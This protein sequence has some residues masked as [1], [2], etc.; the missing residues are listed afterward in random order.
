MCFTDFF[1]SFKWNSCK[2]TDSIL[3]ATSKFTARGET[4]G[5]KEYITS[6]LV[7]KSLGK[8]FRLCI[9][10]FVITTRTI[11]ARLKLTEK[12]LELWSNNDNEDPPM[13]TP[14]FE[15]I[16]KDDLKQ[17]VCEEDRSKNSSAC[18]PTVTTKERCSTDLFHPTSGRGSRAHLTLACA[19][20]VKP[21]TTGFDLIRAVRCEQHALVYD[22]QKPETYTVDGGILRNYGNGVWVVYPQSEVFVSSLFSAFY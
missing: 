14:S 11:G 13:T 10:G 6:P 4:E 8:C 3:H 22:S 19:P 2:D 1:S 15:I 18:V 17:S 21:V 7:R 12:Q 20:N 16:K 9:T 5:A